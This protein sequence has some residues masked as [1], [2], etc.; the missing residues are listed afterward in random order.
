MRAAGQTMIFSGPISPPILG[1][2][3]GSVEIHLSDNLPGYQD[4]LLDL[5][6]YFR[7]KCKNMKLPLYTKDETPIQMLKAG[8]SKLTYLIL[9]KLIQM[10]IF[11]TSAV[12][13]AVPEEDSGIRVTLTRHIKKQDIDKLLDCVNTLFNAITEKSSERIN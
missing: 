13:P 11:A 1:A 12:Y 9:E 8:S 3:I 5:I 6:R 4:E 10:G 7:D 2:L